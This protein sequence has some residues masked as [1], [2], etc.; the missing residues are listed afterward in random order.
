MIMLL[1]GVNA[2]KMVQL[3][4]AATM[5][6]NIYNQFCRVLSITQKL[7]SIALKG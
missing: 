6:S 4:S 5:T 3:R 2:E 7:H 1:K